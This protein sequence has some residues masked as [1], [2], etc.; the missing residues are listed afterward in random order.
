MLSFLSYFCGLATL[1]FITTSLV[2][3]AIRWFHICRPYDRQPDYYYPGRPFVVGIFLNALVLMPYVLLPDSLDAWYLTRLYFLPVTL[4]HFTLLLFSYFG[5]VMQWRQWSVQAVIAGLPVALALLAA[6]VLAVWPGDQIAEGGLVS[7][8]AA[9]CILY[10]LGLV[11]T[12][13]CTVALVIVLRWAWSFDEDDFSNPADFP[14]VSAQKWIGLALVNV[15]LCWAGA[16]FESRALLA[17]IMLLLAASAVVFIVSAL[18]PKRNRPMEELEAGEEIPAVPEQAAP[19]NSKRTDSHQVLLEAIHQ[20]VVQ[21]E[22]Y[23]DPH[24]TIQD[25]ADRI[26]YSRSYIAG[27]FKSEFGGFCNYVNKFRIASVEKYLQDNPDA[28]I[29]EAAE[30]SGFVSRRAYYNVRSKINR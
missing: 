7:P 3:A 22:A 23:L 30:V 28:T 15:V 18:H 4:F 25:V 11:S 17:V 6:L 12:A 9:R 20:V 2:V 10:I 8:F 29:R 16:L 26:G 19:A 21:Q 13:L 1:L 27:I 14:V 5:N 24:L